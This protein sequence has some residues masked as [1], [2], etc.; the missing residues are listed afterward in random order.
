MWLKISVLLAI[1]SN[2]KM[3]VLHIKTKRKTEKKVTGNVGY[4]LQSDN[5][6]KCLT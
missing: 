4:L 2:K 3:I 6:F 1:H 5:V